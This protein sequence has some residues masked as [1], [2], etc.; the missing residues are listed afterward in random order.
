V[1]S[2]YSGILTREMCLKT[3]S[4]KPESGDHERLV[5]GRKFLN[6]SPVRKTGG[7]MSGG[8]K[9]SSESGSSLSGMY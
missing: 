9:H 2:V 1:S 5:G 8:K 7:A 6:M 3:K 4:Q